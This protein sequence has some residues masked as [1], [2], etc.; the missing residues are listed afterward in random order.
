MGQSAKSKAMAMTYALREQH[1]RCT[2]D[3]LGK[4]VR[5]QMKYANKIN[6]LY[7]LI[8]GEDEIKTNKITIKNMKTGEQDELT[9]EEVASYIQIQQGGKQA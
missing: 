6:A 1:I 7:S 3:L 4:S 2:T 5:A 8:I 9:M